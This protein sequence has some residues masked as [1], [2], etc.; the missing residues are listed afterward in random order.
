MRRRLGIARRALGES[1]C[2]ARSTSSTG[3]R[4]SDSF[5]LLV[6]LLRDISSR[7][8]GDAPATIMLLGGDVHTAYVAEVELG[9]QSGR[10]VTSTRSSARRF[11]T[12]S[13]HCNAE[14]SGLAGSR[15]A[16]A[17]LARLARASGVADGPVTWR[18]VRGPTFDN[19]IG[20]L[21]LDERTARLTINRAGENAR[22][23]SLEQLHTL[24]L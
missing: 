17:L 12:R 4:S 1:A 18:F 3:P 2:A 7:V 16:A 13:D 20:T 14:R 19:S 10:R 9:R 6:E 23:P 5:E 21:E 22:E 15:A 24:L 11:A 8:G